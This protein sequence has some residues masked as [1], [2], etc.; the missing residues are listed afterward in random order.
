MYTIAEVLSHVPGWLPELAMP[1]ARQLG[2]W[3]RL[4][5]WAT[6]GTGLLGVLSSVMLYAVTGRQWWAFPRTAFRFFMTAIVTGLA[7]SITV[8]LFIFSTSPR[9]VATTVH[10]LALALLITTILKLAGEASVFAHLR[11]R[12]Q[13]DLKRSALLLRGEL[14]GPTVL[15]FAF[16]MF[17]G[18]AIPGLVFTSIDG[19][20]AS[21]LITLGLVSTTSLVAGE[22][23]ERMNF[24]GALSSPRMPGGL[25]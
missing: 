16:G 7:T 1:F 13:G 17:G 12:Q 5:A 3:Q 19:L 9:L 4:L 22:L 21:V 8:L 18:I 11:D 14:A 6:V 23:L 25:D 2:L 10:V 20:Q 15:R 24:F